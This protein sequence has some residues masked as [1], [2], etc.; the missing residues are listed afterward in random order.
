MNR[1]TFDET[2]GP[3]AQDSGG[4]VNNAG[5]YINAPTPVP[6]VVAGALSFSGNQ[7]IEVANSPELNFGTCVAD[8]APPMTIDLWVKTD[9]QPGTGPTSGLLTILDKR[10]NRSQPNGY[11]LFLFNG[12]L[13]F[14]MDGTNYGAPSS[15]PD[16]VDV[17]DNRWHFVAVSL[18]MC[19]G[20]GGGFLY[21]DG[22]KVL[23]LPRGLGF[24]NTAKLYIGSRDPAF[25][26]NYFRGSL[27]ELEMF[28]SALSED[29]L[30]AIFEARNRGKCRLGPTC[31]GL[32]ATVIGTE[33]NNILRG[34]PGDDVIVGLGGNDI[35]YGL[36][37]N[38]VI[39][40]GDG[41]DIL[42][43]GAGNDRFDGGADNDVLNGESGNDRLL[44]GTGNDV[45]NA[46]SGNDT[47]DGGDGNDICNGG[48]GADTAT[49]C[50]AMSGVP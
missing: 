36:G 20:S 34:T 21:V 33:G 39:C 11:H 31:F 27:D 12:R 6:G 49:N 24:N 28:R 41:N 50:E 15:G 37:G 25:G 23:T 13:G 22:K 43:G 48:P 47:M 3:T 4:S 42:T 9:I 30:R 14:Q 44:G 35:I 26:A 16:Y 2:S 17:A 46:G 1:W 38:D 5:V 29:E 19:R 40:G 18:P 10:A 45:L 7:H 32:P 8:A